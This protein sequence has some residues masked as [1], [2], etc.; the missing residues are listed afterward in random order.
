MVALYCASFRQVPRRIVL[1]LDDTFDPV[2][3]G[4]QLRCSTPTT[5]STA[6]SRC[7]VRRRGP[8]RGCLAAPRVSGRAG[9][10]RAF[11]RR[12]VRAIRKPLANSRGSLIRADRHY[13][14]PG[15]RLLPRERCDFLFGVAHHDA[16]PPSCLEPAPRARHGADGTS[17]AATRSS[18]TAPQLEPRRA[19]HRPRRGRARGHRHRFVVTTSG[20][21]ASIYERLYC[22][23]P[24]GNHIK[25]GSGTSAADRTS[26]CRASANQF[27]L[28]LHTGAYW[29]M[30]SL[31]RLMPA[32]SSWRVAPV[33]HA[34]AA[35]AE[36]RRPRRR[37]EDQ[38]AGPSAQRLSRPSHPAARARTPA[39]PGHL[40]RG[41]CRPDL[42]PFHIDRNREWGFR[43]GPDM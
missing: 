3:G 38:G 14:A 9:G 17:C 24:G 33:R 28:M 10:A 2:H 20:G 31:R 11:L 1:D 6:S 41:Q 18:T 40:T 13:C 27:R 16:A 4:Q 43:R 36:A 25:A 23:R 22:A 7:G 34:A 42:E 30:W 26:C 12:L 5:T 8:A 15:V 21:A 19:H 32:R 39:A 35:P 37:L 29:L